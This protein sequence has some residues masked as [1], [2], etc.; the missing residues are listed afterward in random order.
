VVER[1]IAKWPESTAGSRF[2][3]RAK[4]FITGSDL[5]ES[6]AYLNWVSLLHRDVRAGLIADAITA[7]ADDPSGESVLRTYLVDGPHGPP[8]E[9]LDRAARLDVAAYL[10]EFQLTYMDRMTMAHGLEV[11][12]PLCDYKVIEYALSLPASYRLRGTRS[13]HILKE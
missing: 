9:L 7:D 13:K 4:R 10:P 1:I 3:K 6:E 12:S 11:R 2:A 5:P 8:G